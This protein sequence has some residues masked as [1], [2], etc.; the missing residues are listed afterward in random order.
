MIRTPPVSTC[1]GCH[2]GQKDEG[3]FEEAAYWAR[4]VHAPPGK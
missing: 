4:V 3:R 1:T 2:D